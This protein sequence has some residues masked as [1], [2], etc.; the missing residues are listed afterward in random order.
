MSIIKLWLEQSLH[1]L[2]LILEGADAQF[3]VGEGGVQVFILDY[4]LL[5]LLHVLTLEEVLEVALQ[6]FQNAL[7]SS[8]DVLCLGEI[9]A[10]YTF[11]DLED[12][13]YE[14]AVCGIDGLGEGDSSELHKVDGALEVVEESGLGFVYV[15]GVFGHLLVQ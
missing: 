6:A 3:D 2:R 7:Q 14:L 12:V 9:G 10:L 15:G 13:H 11:V 8:L 5:A 1:L 4:K